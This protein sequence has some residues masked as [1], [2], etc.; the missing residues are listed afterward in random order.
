MRKGLFALLVFLLL[1]LTGCYDAIDL[2]EQIFA[3][4]LALDKGETAALRLTIQIPQI[5]PTGKEPAQSDSDLQKN[6]YVL[7]QVE[8]DTLSECLQLMH[9]V[10]PRRLSLMQLR[11][12]YLSEET[13]ESALLNECL[14]VL[15][16]ARSVRPAAL[17]CITRGRAEDVPK[18]Q[19]PLFGARL[20][21]AQEA[22]YKSL[23]AQGVILH[24]PLK[25]FAAALQ[26]PDAC[27][28]AVLCAVNDL[29]AD[30]SQTNPALP[31]ARYAGEIPRSTADTVDLCGSALIG[32][33]GLLLLN[34]YETQL[35]NL[36]RGDLKTLAFAE[37]SMESLRAPRIRVKTGGAAPVIAV[38]VSL[39]IYAAQ[40]GQIREA[41]CRDILA[42][43]LKLQKHGLD[44]IG[45]ADRTKT[46]A[47]TYADWEDM[48][49]SEQYGSA[50]WE[51][52][53]QD[54][55]A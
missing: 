7:Q 8:G 17:V 47:L 42:L 18:A 32:K 28:A 41:L 16:D 52:T 37:T 55:Q 11:G 5:V 49:W 25:Q 50:A 26:S 22:Q 4:N 14:P 20:S 44:P 29:N 19:L 43:L 35:L 38:D 12:V 15:S 33:E 1:C 21:K 39:R 46:Q 2:N 3:V 30:A 13:A 34:G 24:A 10:T 45:I 23:Q 48:R 6:G 9:M 53:L 27:A 31:A 36:L 54:D 40:S 51:L